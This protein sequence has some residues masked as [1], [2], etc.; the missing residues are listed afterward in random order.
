MELI[1]HIIILERKQKIGN[2][3]CESLKVIYIY[4]EAIPH[5]T[6]EFLQPLREEI[7]WA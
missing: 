2:L 4:G 7:S 3:S 1:K 6:F 5:T